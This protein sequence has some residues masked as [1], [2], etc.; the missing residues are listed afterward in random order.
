MLTG[1]YIYEDSGALV[2]AATDSYR[3]AEKKTTFKAPSDVKLLLPANAMQEVARLLK[4]SSEVVT[5][6]Y[7]EQQAQFMIDG[8][9]VVMRN[10]EGTYPDYKK[11][12]PTSFE[13]TAS[14]I[15]K[16]IVEITKV[17]S[18]FAREAAGSITMQLDPADKQIKINSIASQVGE[19]S[20]SADADVSSDA[21]ITLNSRY[22][23][24][25]LAAFTTESITV[26]V[27]GKLDPCVVTSKDD[28]S[29][30]H[31]IMPVK[32]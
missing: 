19:N 12:L 26:N 32:S 8:S 23:L 31:V 5:M 16:D 13:T 3:L 4:D 1:V 6:S 11:L 18:L 27:N 24:D 7:D 2:F 10:I 14:A 25:S 21:T 9:E 29:Y 22:L 30:T 20:A 28:D 17:S 15:K